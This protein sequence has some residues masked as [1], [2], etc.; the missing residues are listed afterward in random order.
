M[1]VP[2]IFLNGLRLVD[3]G[4]LN[5]NFNSISAALGVSGAS[6][7]VNE[8]IGID[9]NNGG[10]NPS[11][12]LKTL[13]A[14]LALESTALSN[15]GLSSVGRNSVVYFWGTQHRTTS[16]VW[17]LPGTH[18]VG[19]CAPERRG[20][21]ARIS[22]TGS[23]GFNKLVS[24]TAGGCYFANFG[25][26]YGWVDASTALLAWS[27]TAGHS[28]YDNVEFLGF[29]DDT[30]TTGSANL[31]G[32][33]AFYMSTNTGESSFY[34]CVFGVDTT[35]RNAT[36]YTVE[37]AGGAPRL[38]F[39]NCTF[40]A[41]LGS[42]GGAAAHVL[43]GASGIDRYVKFKGCEFYNATNSGATAM[44]QAFS[45]NASPGGTIFLDQCTAGA[46]ITALQTSPANAF[47]M[48]MTLST[49]GGGIAHKVF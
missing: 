30:I 13:D 49:T 40:E 21:R 43:I 38:H 5:S 39:E 17:S 28:C 14:A 47:T 19:L 29:G 16:L 10:Q 41:N 44:N 34:N 45:I 27:D 15:L 6:Y 48:N 3:G 7:Y 26:F 4:Q 18:L 32:S 31:T 22:V 35:V 24:V 36:N 42:S 46:G 20:K 12:P 1:S 11:S 2:F 33:R 25:T 9:N 37:L 23:V 8:T